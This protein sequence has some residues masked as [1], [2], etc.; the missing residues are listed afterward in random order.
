[1]EKKK[2]E[3]TAYVI[4]VTIGITNYTLLKRYS[5]FDDLHQNIKK[6]YKGADLPLLPKKRWFGNTDPSFVQKRCRKLQLY[7]NNLTQIETIFKGIEFSKFILNTTTYDDE[8]DKKDKKE[9]DDKEKDKKEKDDKEKDKKDD[10]KEKR[11][12]K[13]VK[14]DDSEE[15]VWVRALWD[16]LG[17]QH[18]LTFVKGEMI[19]LLQSDDP[20]WWFGELKK[21]RGFFPRLYVER[22]NFSQL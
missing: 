11:S 4:D 18:E 21:R 6:S 20:D 1:M 9:K 5:Q 15:E 19:L 3:F 2:K 12:S 8:K 13:I 14:K 17:S 16:C 7:L 22:V 10:K